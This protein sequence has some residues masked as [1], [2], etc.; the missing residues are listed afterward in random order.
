MTAL[1]KP[2]KQSGVNK[3]KPKNYKKMHQ[4]KTINEFKDTSSCKKKIKSHNQ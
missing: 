2:K 4:Q 1:Q 3:I